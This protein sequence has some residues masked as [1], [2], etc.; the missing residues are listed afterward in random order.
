MFVTVLILVLILAIV[1]LIAALFRLRKRPGGISGEAGRA[2][3]VEAASLSDRFAASL[4]NR[5]GDFVAVIAHVV[6]A[7]VIIF[8]VFQ[9]LYDWT[10]R[11]FIAP[12]PWGLMF[13][14]ALLT[15]I[16]VILHRALKGTYT[17]LK[18]LGVALLFLVTTCVFVQTGR[19]F[20]KWAGWNIFGADPHTYTRGPALVGTTEDHAY[21]VRVPMQEEY[22]TTNFELRKGQVLKIISITSSGADVSG[23]SGDGYQG[24]NA[25]GAVADTGDGVL[26]NL[27]AG[28]E[29]LK[30]EAKL[31][32]LWR[33]RP[34]NN[35]VQTDEIRWNVPGPKAPYGAVLFE[36]NGQKQFLEEGE[37]VEINGNQML[38][39]FINLER[40]KFR[41][42][43][44]GKPR[45]AYVVKFEIL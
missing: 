17:V 25:R 2:R 26:R 19:I 27:I 39:F 14:A 8:G 28:T 7:L 11:F 20:G 40:T 21:E 4:N 37:E 38:G 3:G 32:S 44:T 1:G 12:F 5:P 35:P 33:R 10:S 9:G 43:E 6:V 45:G 13:I 36:L 18:G 41:L 42:N 31:W 29:A 16:G 15:W 22:H 24:C 23:L 30:Y 34:A